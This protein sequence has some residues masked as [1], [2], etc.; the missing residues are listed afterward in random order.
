MNDE[1]TKFQII[2]H[3]TMLVCIS[4]GGLFSGILLWIGGDTVSNEREIVKTMG[5]I[6]LGFGLVSAVY[7]QFFWQEFPLELA[8]DNESFDEWFERNEKEETLY[9]MRQERAFR[10][11]LPQLMKDYANQYVFFEDGRVILSDR[12]EEALDDRIYWAPL[13]FMYLMGR[14]PKYEPYINCVTEPFQSA[15]S[16]DCELFEMLYPNG[17]EES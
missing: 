17:F 14:L 12:S 7:T 1:P 6:F 8:S 5:A 3:R 16:P 2:L 11:C 13:W 9:F 10:K 15:C 4:A